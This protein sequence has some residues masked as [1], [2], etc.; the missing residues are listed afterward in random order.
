MAV[1]DGLLTIAKYLK[2]DI[3]ARLLE[4]GHSATGKLVRSIN[5]K[6]ERG[7]DFITIRGEM[8]FYGQFVVTGRKPG[9][10]GV[11]IADL[12]TWIKNKN[13]SDAATSTLGLAF[14]IQKSIIKKGIK[15]DDFIGFVLKKNEARITRDIFALVDKEMRI[16]IENMIT[17]AQKFTN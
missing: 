16:S 10:R 1:T 12:V 2:F 13:F 17:N 9:A 3:Q 8:I 5:N 14:A 6:V 7:N 4:K 11:P 15:P